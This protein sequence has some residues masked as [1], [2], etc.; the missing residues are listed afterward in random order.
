MLLVPTFNVVEVDNEVV[1]TA[2]IVLLPDTTNDPATNDVVA[3]I[4]GVLID[5][6]LTLFNVLLPDTTND[7]ATNDVVAVIEG[8]LID[9]ALTLFNVVEFNT[10]N[11]L[12]VVSVEIS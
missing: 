6:A 10:F 12:V 4:E 2:A 3:V 7:P 1:L 5:V 9:V 11:V 8:A